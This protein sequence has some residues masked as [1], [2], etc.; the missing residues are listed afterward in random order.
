MDTENAMDEL[1]DD[2]SLLAAESAVAGYDD[3]A[4]DTYGEPEDVAFAGVGGL[5]DEHVERAVRQI[6]ARVYGM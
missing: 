5:Y 4:D 1:Y 2:E 3:F 6:L